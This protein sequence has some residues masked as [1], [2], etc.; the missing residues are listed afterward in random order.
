MPKNVQ[1]YY[2]TTTQE[3]SSLKEANDISID[4]A[5]LLNKRLNDFK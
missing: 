2:V 1:K 4:F 3:G 5:S